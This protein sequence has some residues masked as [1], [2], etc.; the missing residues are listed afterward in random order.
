MTDRVLSGLT[1]SAC[2][3]IL[4]LAASMPARSQAPPGPS[5]AQVFHDAFEQHGQGKEREAEQ[6]FRKGLEMEPG[7]AL[8][9][10]YLGETLRTQGSNDE[11]QRAYEKSLALEPNSKVAASAREHL[12][13]A[14]PAAAAADPS[15]IQLPE[16]YTL[17]D[18]EMR[19]IEQLKNG[20]QTQVLTEG[21][22]YSKQYGA[23]AHL[24]EILERAL[25]DKLAT[26]KVDDVAS[27]HAALSVL[28]PL[29]ADWPKSPAVTRAVARAHAMVLH[30]EGDDALRHIEYDAAVDRYKR[31]L[32]P[33]AQDEPF[34]QIVVDSL[35]FAQQHPDRLAIVHRLGLLDQRLTT[36]EALGPI[37]IG[38]LRSSPDGSHITGTFMLASGD[39]SAFQ[40][41]SADGFHEIKELHGAK[42]IIDVSDDGS[43]M[44][45]RNDKGW[46]RWTVAHGIE[47][48]DKLPEISHPC[49]DRKYWRASFDRISNDGSGVAGSGSGFEVHTNFI[50][51]NSVD[52]C[53]VLYVVDQPKRVRIV[54]PVSDRSYD[55]ADGSSG[56]SLSSQRTVTGVSP[57]GKTLSGYSNGTFQ[58][59]WIYDGAMHKHSGEDTRSA[60]SCSGA[61][62][63]VDLVAVKHDGHTTWSVTKYGAGGDSKLGELGLSD[64]DANGVKL[65]GVSDDCSVIIGKSA[66][67][68]KGGQSFAFA[69]SANTGLEKLLDEQGGMVSPSAISGDGSKIFGVGKDMASG[70]VQL[71]QWLR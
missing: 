29:A 66:A 64:Q 58:G 51:T 71:V 47:P 70:T 45:G 67:A 39:N 16:G 44:L 3:A 20:Q 50:A 53:D 30:E 63:L 18:W 57:D 24:D 55:N 59:I 41:S 34:R 54:D 1:V 7:N 26:I 40:W 6:L 12:A 35:M 65:I 11:S 25:S 52:F 62:K 9:W 31:A 8:A 37:V 49:S 42:S 2:A 32:T 23:V 69:W 21:V 14:K 48:L 38:T 68:V 36:F 61:S 22:R 13:H 4:S 56:Q 15:K 5:A 43:A 17:A 27:A 60:K 19:A 10:F 33:L 46:Y 28:D